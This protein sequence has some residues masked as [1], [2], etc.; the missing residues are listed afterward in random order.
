MQTRASETQ[1]WDRFLAAALASFVAVLALGLLLVVAM[2]PYGNL[3]KLL[4]Q[5]HVIMDSDQRFQYPSIIRSGQFDSAVIGNS[6]SRLLEPEQ[7]NAIFGGHFANLG[8]NDSRAWEQLQVTR[9]LLRHVPGPRTLVFGLDWVWCNAD[10]GVNRMR[11]NEFPEW[12]YAANRWVD[13]Q[14]VLN[15]RAIEISIRKLG[16]HLGWGKPR[17]PPDGYEVFVPPDATYD[18]VKAS[19]KIWDGPRRTIAAL[20]PAETVGDA[21]I[22]G[23]QFPALAW[24]E[25]LSHRIPKQTRVMFVF[26]PAHIVAL[27]VPGSKD[28]RRLEVCKQRV[29][30]IAER[31]GAPVIDFRFPSALTERDENFWDNLHYR[32][33]IAR[34]ITDALRD[35][36]TGA[37]GDA[38]GVWRRLQ[39][40]RKT[41]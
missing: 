24:L 1:T 19:A 22:A 15:A 17:F 14:Y 31:I 34:L 5:R 30:S 26:V 7:L 9:L 4:F 32:T 25:E 23:W 2:N 20:V 16:Y 28:A 21:E 40:S 33:G 3:P 27:P 12:L 18:A 11:T 35:S 6:S 37:R 8:I 10:A 38:A 36:Q 13:W 29:A 41:E 39:A